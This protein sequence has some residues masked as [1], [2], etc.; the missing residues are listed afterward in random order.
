MVHKIAIGSDHAGFNLK[1]GLKQ[2]LAGKGFMVRDFGTYSLD[3]C[4]YPDFAY[5]LA[6]A[7]S[8]GKFLRGILI[9]KSG[10]GNS[11]VAN[12]VRG[13]RAGLCYNITVARL[14]REH[15]DSNILV[16]GSGFVRPALA[17]RIL[18]VW[19][20]TKFS[21]GRHQRRLNKIKKIEK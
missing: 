8:A 16:L 13:I 9:C 17:K 12:K 20:K 2:Y 1:E 3:S 14:C 10:I 15:N 19:L 5:P 18:A 4:D 6:K 7:V 21:G 11:I